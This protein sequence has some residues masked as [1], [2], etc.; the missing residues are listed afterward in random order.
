MWAILI[1]GKSVFFLLLT[2]GTIIFDKRS[3]KINCEF[4]IRKYILIY[5]LKYVRIKRTQR[6][7]IIIL[8]YCN[9]EFIL[10]KIDFIFRF[11]TFSLNWLIL[12]N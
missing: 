11:I 2:V 3:I 12:K 6:T 8:I 4:L 5:N 1:R 10:I 9:I 7:K